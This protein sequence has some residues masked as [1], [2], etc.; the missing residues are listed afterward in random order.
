MASVEVVVDPVHFQAGGQGEEDLAHLLSETG[1]YVVVV[2]C[3]DG[4]VVCAEIMVGTVRNGVLVAAGELG[5]VAEIVDVT[6]FGNQRTASAVGVHDV[7]GIIAVIAENVVIVTA[8]V[9]GTERTHNL[10]FEAVAV[11]EIMAQKQ[12]QRW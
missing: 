7:R 9:A 11:V 12:V 8:V 2:L 1:I 6:D 3:Q 4:T 5:A 10:G